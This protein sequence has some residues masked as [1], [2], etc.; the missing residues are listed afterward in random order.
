VS[1]HLP[2][3]HT[4]GLPGPVGIPWR[5]LAGVRVGLVLWGGM[6]LAGLGSLSHTP[7]YAGVGQVAAHVA[8]ASLG[9][10]IRTATAAGLVGWLVVDGFVVHRFGVLG[11]DGAPDVARLV[12][13]L[14]LATAATR[15]RG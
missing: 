15:A 14:G 4:T 8:A 5:E 2:V 6:A 11:F 10:T 12:L 1:I 13:L 7:A 9:T 3:Q